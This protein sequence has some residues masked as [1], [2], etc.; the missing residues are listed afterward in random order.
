MVIKRRTL[1]IISIVLVIA[2]IAEW[3]YAY[4]FGEAD[5]GHGFHGLCNSGVGAPYQDFVH[6]LRVLAESGDTNALTATLRTADQRS[7]DM[8]E[9]WLSYNP[10]AYKESLH[11]ILP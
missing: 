8:F 9:V 11:Q 5:A 10:D 4:S 1:V 2:A 6:R 7:R 3:H